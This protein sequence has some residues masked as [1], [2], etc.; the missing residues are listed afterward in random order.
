MHRVLRRA[1]N[2]AYLFASV[3]T[4]CMVGITQGLLRAVLEDDRA[5][6]EVIEKH[7]RRYLR[8]RAALRFVVQRDSRCDRETAEEWTDSM[9]FGRDEA[10]SGPDLH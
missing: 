8:A 4:A 1:R 10:S 3:T 7:R 6:A 2:T 5:E 9:G